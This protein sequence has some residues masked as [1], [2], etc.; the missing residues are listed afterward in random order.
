MSGWPRRCA[1]WAILYSVVVEGGLRPRHMGTL[2][3]APSIR[4]SHPIFVGSKA[5]NLPA[6][7]VFSLW[8]A[9]K[10]QLGLKD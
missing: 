5:P 10:R 2:V 6:L 3:G 7:A 9:N 8:L 1:G 4:P